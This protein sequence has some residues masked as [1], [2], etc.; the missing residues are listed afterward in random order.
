MACAIGSIGCKSSN[1]LSA[2]QSRF[3]RLWQRS[4]EALAHSRQRRALAALDRR[5][6]DDIGLPHAEAA[7]EIRKPFWK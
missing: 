2:T 3:V 1:D 4:R 6:L 5:L 7:Q